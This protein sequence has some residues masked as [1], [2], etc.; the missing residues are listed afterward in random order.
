MRILSV[1]NEYLI[2]G[3]EDESRKAEVSVLEQYGNSVSSYIENNSKVATLSKTAAALRTL[4][5]R[6]SYREVRRLLKQHKHDAIHVQNF[7]PLISPSVYYAAQ[8]E[9]VPVIQ[10]VRNYRF[11]CPNAMLYRDGEVCEL[12]LTK[13]IK[14][15]AVQHKCYRDNAAASA[16]ATS[17]LMLHNYL[18]TWQQIDRFVSVSEFVKQKMI[19]GGFPAEK[20]VVKPNFVY[21]DPGVCFTK[22]DYIVYVGRL[23]VEKGIRTLLAALP[24]LSKSVRVKVVGEGPLEQ[25]VIDC[26]K[27]YNIEYLGK[28]TLAETYSIIGKARALVI[29]SLWHEPFGRVVVEAYA[30]GT[31]VIGARMGGI[32]ELIEDG[33][34][35]YTFKAGQ[36]DDLVDKIELVCSNN[37]RSTEMGLEGR[38]N[39]ERKYTPASN[40]AMLMNIYQQV[41]R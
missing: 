15:A 7:F 36:I 28:K 19:E 31:T 38:A 8:T 21:P 17:M 5:S 34:T 10:A 22:E 16:T 32:P 29:P 14:T 27:Q 40:Y 26:T 41:A 24:K 13:M 35:G 20:I 4:W 9:R 23:Q 37:K 6:E 30:K 2:K 18:P 25:E 39:Y 3:G 11:V 33:R 1:H 12:C